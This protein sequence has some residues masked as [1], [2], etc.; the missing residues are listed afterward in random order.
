MNVTDLTMVDA[1]RF[2]K[3]RGNKRYANVN[4]VLIC[5]RI[6]HAK[7]VSKK[8]HNTFKFRF[9]GGLEKILLTLFAKNHPHINLHICASS[10]YA[11]NI[12]IF[13]CA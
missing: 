10:I 6:K 3:R 5:S 11:Q 8:L 7:N 2:A 1:P 13:L 9:E 4:L 12:T